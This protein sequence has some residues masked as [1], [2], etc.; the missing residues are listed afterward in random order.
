MSWEK[1]DKI[2]WKNSQV[3]REFEK[4]IIAIM[5]K[6]NEL[7]KEANDQI[8]TQNMSPAEKGAYYGA[9]E[10]AMSGASKDHTLEDQEK[11]SEESEKEDAVEKEAQRIISDLNIILKKAQSKSDMVAVYN[12][13]RAIQEIKDIK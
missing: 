5:G 7:N 1:E 9:K 11:D 8:A 6:I 4:Q 12:I 10:K 13:E 3:M 2:V